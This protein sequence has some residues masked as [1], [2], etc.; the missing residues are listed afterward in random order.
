MT[1]TKVLIVSPCQG[2]YG[3]IEAFV[4]AVAAALRRET[5]MEVRICLKRVRGFALQ[6]DLKSMLRGEDVIWA[7]P[8]ADRDL[9]EGIKSADIVHLQNASPDVAFM[10]KFFRKPLVMTIHNYMTREMTAHRTSVAHRGASCER[11]LVQLAVCLGHMGAATE[12]KR[13][14]QSSDDIEAAGRLD[15]A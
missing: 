5:D 11:A 13:Q 15:A 12:T 3:G 6:P 4:L 10:A 9:I 1:K 7:N 8:G 14:P 2:G